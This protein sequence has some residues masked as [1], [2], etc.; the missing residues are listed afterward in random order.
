MTCFVCDAFKD[1]KNMLS[2][3]HDIISLQL[4][5]FEL[6]FNVDNV[7]YL[8]FQCDENQLYAT[9]LEHVIEKANKV[10]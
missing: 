1:F 4:I 3:K 9:H 2:Y 8:V 7:E 6:Y 5:T 10:T